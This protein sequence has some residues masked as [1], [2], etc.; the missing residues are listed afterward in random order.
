MGRM[1]RVLK[2]LKRD[3]ENK[4]RW[5]HEV[6][7]N[8][9]YW[10][11]HCTVNTWYYNCKAFVKNLWLFLKLAWMWRPWDYSYTVNALVQLLTRQAQSLKHGYHTKSE[12]TYRRCL[13]AAGKLD[14][15]YNKDLDRTI[16][17]ILRKNP[18][19]FKPLEGETGYS[20]K[21][22]YNISKRIY[23]G[24]YDAAHKRSEAAEKAQKEEAWKYLHKYIEHFWD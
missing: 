20:M 8:I 22:D 10:W 17:Y 3:L 18:M 2:S 16:T 12:E 5:Y 1:S 6:Y 4:T 11:D 15:A 21:I 13:T 9:W 14:R 19:S 23:D 7:D 24:M